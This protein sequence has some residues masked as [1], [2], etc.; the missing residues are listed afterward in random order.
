[1]ANTLTNLIPN[2][3]VALDVVSQ[4]LVGFIPA[5]A[6]NSTA[7]RVA[8]NQTLYSPVTASNTSGGNVTPAMSLPSVSDQTIGTESLTITKQRAFKFSWTGEEQNSMDAGPGYLNL[9]QDMIAQCLRAAVNEIETDIAVAAKN[10]AS[11]AYGAPGTAPFASTLADPANVRKILDDNG[12]PLSDRHLVINT[13][14][15]AALRTLATVNKVNEVGTGSLLNQGVLIDLHGF[16]IRESAQIQSTTKGTG[17]S[18]VLNGAHAAGATDIVI[19]TGSGTVVA[20]DVVTIN[21]VKYVVKTGASAAGTITINK[22]GLLTAGSDGNTVT[23]NDTAA[24]NIAFTRNAIVL[25][26]RVP[27]A[28]KGGDMAIM[29]EIITDP[30]TGISFEV[31]VYPGYRMNVVEVAACWGVTAFKPE[32]IAVLQG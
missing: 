27:V 9:E 24:R 12:A 18:Y 8:I 26:T 23:V 7:D 19:K 15:G 22:P 32:H 25:A 29:R 17:T 31:S 16:R 20:G 10:A 6:R 11:R 21:S 13:T 2:A 4:E 14:A 3:Y 1:M 28:P 30:R 5:V